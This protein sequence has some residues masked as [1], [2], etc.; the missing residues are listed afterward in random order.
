M[1]IVAVVAGIGKP[2]FFTTCKEC[3]KRI[4]N[5]VPPRTAERPEGVD[6]F[7]DLD[8]EP[9][10]FYCFACMFPKGETNE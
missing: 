4:S 7:A 9:F 2:V 5:T 8:G 10:A 6:C 3:G 1:K